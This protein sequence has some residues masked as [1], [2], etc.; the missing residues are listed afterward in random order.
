M[1]YRFSIYNPVHNILKLYNFLV[2]VRFTISK[3][4]LDI[5][6]NKLGKNNVHELPNDLR[7]R[8]SRNQ[9]ILE[10]SRIWSETQL[11]AQSPFSKFNFGNSSQKCKLIFFQSCTIL[12]NFFT[13]FQMIPEIFSFIFFYYY[14]LMGVF[15]IYTWYTIQCLFILPYKN[16][17]LQSRP[18]QI[19]DN[20]NLYFHV[21]VSE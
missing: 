8:K 3:T 10:K 21:A 2:Q 16:F 15:D 17:H 11:R 18:E 5:S 20:F 7:F 9:K 13:L 19:C 6:Y 1:L 12:M 14:H 4:K